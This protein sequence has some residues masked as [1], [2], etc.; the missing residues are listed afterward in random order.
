MQ[1][2]FIQLFNLWQLLI[3]YVWRAIIWFIIILD[4]NFL[5]ASEHLALEERE[6]PCCSVQTLQFE[7]EQSR[8]PSLYI[9][10]PC[11]KTSHSIS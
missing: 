11:L 3:R 9:Y 10:L 8:S 4:S 7:E 1:N 2:S 6:D 5:A